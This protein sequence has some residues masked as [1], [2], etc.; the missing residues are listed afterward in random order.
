[1]VANKTNTSQF[2]SKLLDVAGKFG[3]DDLVDNFLYI[4]KERE[5]YLQEQWKDDLADIGPAIFRDIDYEHLMVLLERKLSTHDDLLFQSK[6]AFAKVCLQFNQFEKAYSILKPLKKLKLDP[7]NNADIEMHLGRLDL[8]RNQYEESIVHYKKAVE[9]YSSVDE[10]RGQARAYNNLGIIAHEQWQAETGEGY[11]EK[12]KALSS[13]HEDNYTKTFVKMNLGIVKALKGNHDEAL[14]IFESLLKNEAG[15]DKNVK[16]H[17]IVNIGVSAKDSNKLDHAIQVLNNAVQ[18]ANELNNSR[19]LALARLALGEAYIYINEY[20]KSDLQLV[21]G[22]KLF[23]QI[24]DKVNMADTYRIFGLLHLENDQI[25]LAESE[26]QI[27][28]RINKEKGNIPNLAESF[29]TYARLDEVKGDTEARKEHLQ[30]ALSLCETMQA[31]FR[32]QRIK[33]ELDQLGS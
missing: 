6:L 19:L 4:K 5:R 17:L 24:H 30:K 22:F 26:I 23:S 12:A 29:R 32:A 7:E 3:E 2:L 21:K 33:E 27:S 16:L 20:E 31:T 13:D 8:L 11:F 18:L 28:I 25:E 1:M 9:L 10:Y 14:T 15:Y